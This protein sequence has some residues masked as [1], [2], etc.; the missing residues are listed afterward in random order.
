MRRPVVITGG[1]TGGHIFPMQAIAEALMAQGAL[2][3]DLLFVGS[4][5]GKERELLSQQ[6]TPLVL[7]PGRGIQRSLSPRALLQNCGAV[8]GLLSAQVRA[9]V[10]VGRLRPA[11]VVSV[12]G[13]A[14]FAMS[15]AAVLWRRPLVLVE[16]DATQ[17]AAHRV[18][19]RFAAR[20]C[21]AFASEDARDV[22]TGAP[23]RA[24][25]STIDRSGARVNGAPRPR[26]TIVVMT[27]SLGAS[28]VNRAVLALADTWRDRDDLTL[29]HVTGDRDFAWVR[30]GHDVRPTDRLDYR[31]EAFGDMT[32][33]WAT[34]DL[35]LCRAGAMTVAELT[36]LG[37]PSILVPLPNAPGDHQAKNARVLRDAGAA[38]VM[39]DSEV[40]GEALD[41]VVS[42]ILSHPD[43]LH[44]M[45]RAARTLG[46]A[47]AADAI[48]R[49]VR[50][51]SA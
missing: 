17:G 49:V 13:Y 10:I 28:S 2:P 27:G 19:S 6:S 46:H 1:G 32:T 31:V 20:R 41:R 50:E 40:S 33:L 37:I 44:E 15:M 48:A 25:I 36:Y 18:V 42:D 11:A 21:V 14:S 12:G 34:C 30:D 26:W 4:R 3:T 5:R 39:T 22:V 29:V 45:A 35:A 43:R 51:V 7:L 8:L 9:L 24:T 23:L 16:F 47:N 38:I